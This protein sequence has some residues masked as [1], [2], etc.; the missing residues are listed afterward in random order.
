MTTRRC[1]GAWYELFPRSYSPTPG[2]HGT[3]RDL[4][5]HLPYVS[6]MG[7]DVLYLPPVHPVGTAFRKGKNNAET[8]RTGGRGQPVGYWVEGGRA[9]GDSSGP[10]I[11][12]GF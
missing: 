12:G 5:E 7:F 9:Q 3:L 4:I 6:S 2:E 8:A 11:V 1:S 10:G